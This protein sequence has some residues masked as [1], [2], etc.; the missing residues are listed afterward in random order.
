MEIPIYFLFFLMVNRLVLF[1]SYF[2]LHCTKISYFDADFQG[3]YVPPDFEE[4]HKTFH[5]V[6]RF[7]FC[8][9]LSPIFLKLFKPVDTISWYAVKTTIFTID[10]LPKQ[11]VKHITEID[12]NS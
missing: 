11:S 1:W 10:I 7:S 8:F 5:F 2:A 3:S 6:V 12:F 4:A 9:R